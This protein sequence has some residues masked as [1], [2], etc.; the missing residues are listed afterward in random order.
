MRIAESRKALLEERARLKTHALGLV[1]T[2]GNLHEGHLELVRAARELAE[3]VWV[4]LFVNPL[5]FGEGEDF[6]T[7]PRTFASDVAKLESVGVDLLFAPGVAD[8][9]PGGVEAPVKLALP[10]LAAEMCGAHR[11][12]HFEG[13]CTAVLKLLN[14]VRPQYVCFGEKDYQQLTLVRRMVRDLHVRVEVVPVPTV[15]ESDGLAMS[16]RNSY[17]DADERR[18]AP[19]LYANLKRVASQIELGERDFGALEAAAIASLRENGWVPEYIE[20]RDAELGSP[21]AASEF[22]VLGAARLGRTRLIDNL[23]AVSR[24]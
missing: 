5:Q 21:E 23:R 10:G 20:V 13:A 15:R 14:L 7:Y 24:R 19:E 3:T 12:G 18:R 4:S 9:Y 17:L 11:P 22:R 2:M 1:P 8:M 6:E 16:S